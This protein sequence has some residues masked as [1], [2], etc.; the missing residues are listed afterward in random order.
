MMCTVHTKRA[1]KYEDSANEM[2]SIVQGER[3][4]AFFKRV[5]LEFK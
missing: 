4:N 5:S 3:K 1:W 2:M